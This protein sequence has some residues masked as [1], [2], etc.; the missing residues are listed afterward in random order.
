MN[1]FRQGDRCSD[2]WD[3]AFVLIDVRRKPHLRMISASTWAVKAAVSFPLP[4]L[5]KCV[6]A[7]SG[8]IHLSRTL[9]VASLQRSY[10]VG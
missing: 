1:M 2:G 7:I 8:W 3:S 6:A 4:R 10:F 5:W 9:T